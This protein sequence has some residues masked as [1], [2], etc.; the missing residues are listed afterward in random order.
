MN[1]VWCTW[2]VTPGTLLLSAPVQSERLWRCSQRPCGEHPASWMVTQLKRELGV[3]WRRPVD[4]QHL[5]KNTPSSERESFC[6]K[7]TVHL[8]NTS[9]CSVIYP[10]KLFCCEFRVVCPLSLWCSKSYSNAFEKNST[11]M[12]PSKNLEPVTQDN[13]QT[14]LWA[15]TDKGT[16]HPKK[17]RMP[18]SLSPSVPGDCFDV[19]SADIS[20]KDVCLL[21]DVIS[22][23]LLCVLCSCSERFCKFVFL[24][25]THSF[26][27]QT[28][29]EVKDKPKRRPLVRA[30]SEES[31]SDLSSVTYSPS[32]GDTLPWNLPKH[33]RMK[34]S[35][36][37]SGDVLD[38]A[39]RAV[40]RIAGTMFHTE[41]KQKQKCLW[42]GCICL[43]TIHLYVLL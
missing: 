34:R 20:F 40:I 32:P 12:S 36:S 31:S 7:G 16:V 41:R 39:E 18:V 2:D 10:S 22:P 25:F 5:P 30:A 24:P 43:P 29:E 4:Q 13:L 3:W 26:S 35:K 11:A 21:S 28:M 37:A 33:H 17:S 42:G 19:S 27:I 38:P 9:T 15:W 23:D 1:C 14:F 6:L 8:K